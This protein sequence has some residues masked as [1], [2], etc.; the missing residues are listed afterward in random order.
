MGYA[1]CYTFGDFLQI[2]ENVKIKA[3]S[4]NVLQEKYLDPSPTHQMFFPWSIPHASVKFYGNPFSSSTVL[5]YFD[6]LHVSD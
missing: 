6:I 2:T 1:K 4:C 3:L 5:N